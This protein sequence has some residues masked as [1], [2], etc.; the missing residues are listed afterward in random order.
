[1]H[2]GVHTCISMCVLG[3]GVIRN[4]LAKAKQENK[5]TRCVQIFIKVL[6]FVGICFCNVLFHVLSFSRYF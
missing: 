4:L 2:G 5:V 1:M 6:A 3:V